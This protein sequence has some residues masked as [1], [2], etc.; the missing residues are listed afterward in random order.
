[1][2]DE[3]PGGI[4]SGGPIV[5][6]SK[7]ARNWATLC[8][9]GGGLGIYLIPGLGHIIVPLVVW[10]LKKDDF[11]FVDD[12]GKEA[13][14]FQISITLYLIAAGLSFL[15]CVGVVLFPV[16]LVAD[17]ALMIL[18]AIRAS[19]GELYRYPLTIRFLQ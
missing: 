6:P 13:V 15:T 12:Q 7:E 9:L 19:N 17:F 5:E 4:G 16:V 11:A 10:L 1:M 18:A 3:S 8:H 2:S 14:N